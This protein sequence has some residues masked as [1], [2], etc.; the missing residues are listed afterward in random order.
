MQS[1]LGTFCQTT[2][3]LIVLNSLSNAVFYKAKFGVVEGCLTSIICLNFVQLLCT[4]ILIPCHQELHA[5]NGSSQVKCEHNTHTYAVCQD[6][7]VHH[8]STPQHTEVLEIP[9]P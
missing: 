6:G 9:F 3:P 8:C 1:Q 5:Q 7:K 4:S 2:P